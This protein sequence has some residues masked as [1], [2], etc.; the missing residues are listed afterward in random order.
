MTIHLATL[1]T[2]D[3]ALMC[4]LLLLPGAYLLV[5]HGIGLKRREIAYSVALGMLANIVSLL[6]YDTRGGLPGATVYGWPKEY[7]LVREAFWHYNLFYLAIDIVFYTA[8]A[9]CII[10][11]RKLKKP[12]S[13]DNF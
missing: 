7:I 13:M 1:P 2:F 4:I 10:S 8:V 3:I 12:Y 5:R 11:L 9:F 6:F